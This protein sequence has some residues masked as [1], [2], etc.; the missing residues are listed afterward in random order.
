MRRWLQAR[1][2]FQVVGEA[3]DGLEAVRLAAKSQPDVVLMEISMPHMNGLEATAQL[4]QQVPRTRVIIHSSSTAAADVRR[5]LEAGAAAYWVM[6]G[7]VRPDVIIDRVAAGNTF[8]DSSV[9]ME[10][11]DIR[12]EPA[13][14]GAK[15]DALTAGAARSFPVTP[16][17][18]K[19]S[20]PDSNGHGSLNCGSYESANLRSDQPAPSLRIVMLTDESLMMS[21]VWLLTMFFEEV[22]PKILPQWASWSY[23]ALAVPRAAAV[24]TEDVVAA[25][26]V[27]VCQKT[28]AGLPSHVEA[29]LHTWLRGKRQPQTK[30][31]LLTLRDDPAQPDEWKSRLRE[32]ARQADLPFVVIRD[33]LSST[34]DSRVGARPVPPPAEVPYD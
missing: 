22:S 5:A 20:A 1:P 6:G 32:L 2:R 3:R 23:A 16:S 10:A 13:S 28:S 8:V 14:N 31:G 17:L 24:A 21:Y 11:M 19:C 27:V 12:L 25:D 29:W 33:C 26:W 34:L 4:T 9:S 15:P 18:V 7:D 30:L